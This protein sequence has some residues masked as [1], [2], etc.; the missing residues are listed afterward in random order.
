MNQ[1]FYQK[2][3]ITNI[4]KGVEE[5]LSKYSNYSRVALIYA[6]CKDDPV[7]VF[8][9]QN[10]LR[11]HESKLKE[12][13]YDN[14]DKWQKSVEEKITGQPHGYIASDNRLLLSGLISHAGC[15]NEFFYQMWFTDH[16]PDMCSIHPTQRWLEQAASLLVHDY[17]SRVSALNSSDYVLKNYALQAIADFIIDQREENLGFDSKI[18]I[19]PVLNDILNIS[20]TREE[21]SWVRGILFFT[22]PQ[23]LEETPVIAKIQK[24]ERPVISNVKHIRKLLVAVENSPRKLVSDGCTIIGFTDCDIPDFAIAADFRGDYGF[25]NFG[26]KKIASFFDGSFHS[27]TRKA[28]MVELEEILLDVSLETEKA[29]LLFQV[30]SSLVHEAAK[31][32]YGCTLVIDLNDTPVSLS[33]HI[34]DPSLSLLEPKNQQFACSLLKIDGAVHITSDLYI[35]GFGCLLDGKAVNWENMARGARYNSAL[36]FSAEHSHVIIVVVSSDRPVSIVY[37][38][39]EL[40]AFSFWRPV[41]Q[42]TPKPVNLE[43]YLTRGIL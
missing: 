10:I 8:D 28:R 18:M 33:G 21:G 30:V 17:N 38:G 20:K 35:H 34:L 13:F 24:Y 4:V 16:H 22:D 3:C 40:N 9:P 26:N 2:L 11:G 37:N 42:F 39:I 1:T 25:L 19:T 6:A 43:K 36:R 27:T 31:A 12:M 7:I 29:T 23:R 32:R 41:Y 15:S 5:G 14:H